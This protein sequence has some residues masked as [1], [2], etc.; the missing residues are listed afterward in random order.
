MAAILSGTPIDRF[1]IDRSARAIEDLYRSKGYYQARVEL[2][3]KTLA[4]SQIVVF[5]VVEGVIRST[6]VVDE[7]GKIEQA[8]YNVNL[9]R[10]Y[11]SNAVLANLKFH[12]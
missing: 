9:Y 7:D 3:E 1:Q 10:D 4:E 11:T 2:D 5:K 12:F 8:Q 6:F